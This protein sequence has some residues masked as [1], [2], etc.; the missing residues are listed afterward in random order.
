MHGK[1]TRYVYAFTIFYTIIYYTIYCFYKQQV[2]HCRTGK[3]HRIHPVRGPT[4][5][6]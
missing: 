4:A 6:Y 3:I 1:I 5:P 2:M